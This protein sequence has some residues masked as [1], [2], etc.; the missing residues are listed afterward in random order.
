VEKRVSVRPALLLVPAGAPLAPACLYI[1]TAVATVPSL[2]CLW[3]FT[4]QE[5][6]G[7]RQALK[8]LNFRRAC[9]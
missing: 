1:C 9:C 8:P 5:T 4:L 2:L 7:H 3:L 6:V